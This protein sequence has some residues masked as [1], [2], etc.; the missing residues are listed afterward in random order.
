M[1]ACTTEAMERSENRG[2]TACTVPCHWPM[3][4]RYFRDYH[5]LL[6]EQIAPIFAM[7]D[8]IAEL[9][10]QLGTATLYS[11]SD[12]ARYQRL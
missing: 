1:T 10:R 8:V 6:D 12:I 4:G 2:A 7:I 11:I 9:A 5:L 3:R